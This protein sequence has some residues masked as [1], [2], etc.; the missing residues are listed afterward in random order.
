MDELETLEKE[1]EELKSKIKKLR[2]KSQIEID[3]Q[4]KKEK[5]IKK[6]KKIKNG[7][8]EK[9]KIKKLDS[10]K[11]KES[12]SNGGNELI[13]VSNK[14]KKELEDID[15]KRTELKFVNIS[16]PKKT[17]LIV[18]HKDWLK[19]KKDL[20]NF[21]TKLEEGKNVIN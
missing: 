16:H 15:D 10:K 17:E 19:K 18:R 13:R 12:Y 7:V 5:E 4:V 14:F 2:K 11:R 20:I 3:E 9:L 6:L 1:K 8:Q 21:D